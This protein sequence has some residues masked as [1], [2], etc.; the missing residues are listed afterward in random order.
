[1]ENVNY[2]YIRDFHYPSSASHCARFVAGHCGAFHCHWTLRANDA[3]HR[4]LFRARLLDGGPVLC[5]VWICDFLRVPRQTRNG[6]TSLAVRVAAVL[7]TI[8]VAL[9]DASIFYSGRIGKAGGRLIHVCSPRGFFPWWLES[10][11]H[12]LFSATELQ[13][14]AINF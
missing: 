5:S 8:S 10:D 1:M 12:Q 4:T 13:L 3:E 9:R 2:R 11:S 14:R 7:A 6:E